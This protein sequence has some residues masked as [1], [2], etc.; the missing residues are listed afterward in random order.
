[1]TVADPK[2]L[3]ALPQLRSLNVVETPVRVNGLAEPRK[4]LPKC[5]IKYEFEPWGRAR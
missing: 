3:A 1:V 2:E 5:T 4:A